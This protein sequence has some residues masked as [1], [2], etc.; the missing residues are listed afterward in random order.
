LLLIALTPG[1]WMCPQRGELQ[2]ARPLP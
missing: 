1:S 2:I